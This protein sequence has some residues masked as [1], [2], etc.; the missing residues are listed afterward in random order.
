MELNNTDKGIVLAVGAQRAEHGADLDVVERARPSRPTKRR[1]DAG[2]AVMLNQSWPRSDIAV[3]RPEAAKRMD[4]TV[5]GKRS[6]PGEP[7]PRD[8]DHMQSIPNEDELAAHTKTPPHVGAKGLIKP[9]PESRSEGTNRHE[10]LFRDPRQHR[11]KSGLQV[12]LRGL[13]SRVEPSP[14]VFHTLLGGGG[15]PIQN[16][17]QKSG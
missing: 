13:N 7:S 4:K 16:A 9:V 14:S 15:S 1:D 17:L 5:P 12:R 6:P 3:D 2:D 8:L 10:K 11:E